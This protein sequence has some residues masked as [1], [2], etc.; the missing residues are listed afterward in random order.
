MHTMN[1]VLS[2]WFFEFYTPQFNG[3]FAVLCN[4]D[5]D[6]RGSTFIHVPSVELMSYTMGHVRPKDVP[7]H[8]VQSMQLGSIPFP[9]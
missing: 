8:G 4:F 7:N 6:Y 9:P 2:N 3:G 5:S 1:C